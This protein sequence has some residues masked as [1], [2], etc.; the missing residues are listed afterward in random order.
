MSNICLTLFPHAPCTVFHF[1]LFNQ[2]LS[3]LYIYIYLPCSILFYFVLVFLTFFYL[4]SKYF[5]SFSL[6]VL[7]PL[8]LGCTMVCSC[9]FMCI[10]A[11]GHK[12]FPLLDAERNMYSPYFE[13]DRGRRNRWSSMFQSNCCNCRILIV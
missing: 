3:C 8:C 13:V 10:L 2:I 12:P 5:H 4:V 7:F 9:V 6:L 1:F 11:V